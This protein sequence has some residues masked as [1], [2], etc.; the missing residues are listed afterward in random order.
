MHHRIISNKV[1]CANKDNALNFFSFYQDK[2]QNEAMIIGYPVIDLG[3]RP[4]ILPDV[5]TP[6]RYKDIGHGETGTKLKNMAAISFTGTTLAPGPLR[7][8]FKR[9]A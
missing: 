3:Y 6:S 5:K 2:L 9:F 8:L 1:S 7:V 4:K